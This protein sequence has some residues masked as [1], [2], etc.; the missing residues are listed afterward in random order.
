M[1]NQ[2][3]ALEAHYSRRWWRFKARNSAIRTPSLGI[4]RLNREAKQKSK[5]TGH[6]R[7]NWDG[8]TLELKVCDERHWDSPEVDINLMQF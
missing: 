6:V 3:N 4:S 5:R 1:E 8:I 7:L 2:V